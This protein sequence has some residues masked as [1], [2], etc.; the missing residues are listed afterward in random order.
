M[1]L[2]C[3][4]ARHSVCVCGP[5]GPRSCEAYMCVHCV[6][7]LYVYIVC[8]C[9]VCAC[10]QTDVTSQ[11]T[12]PLHLYPSSDSRALPC[13]VCVCQCGHV[14]N[15]R[16]AVLS[17]GAACPFPERP[18]AGQ[19]VCPKSGHGPPAPISGCLGDIRAGP[20]PQSPLPAAWTGPPFSPGVS[21]SPMALGPQ[22]KGCSVAGAP[23]PPPG[24]ALGPQLP[25]SGPQVDQ[26]ICKGL[27]CPFYASPASYDVPA[28]WLLSVCVLACCL[29]AGVFCMFSDKCVPPA[30]AP[31]TIEPTCAPRVPCGWSRAWPG[32]SAPLPPPPCSHPSRS[33]LRV[34]PMYPWVDTRSRHA[35]S[36]YT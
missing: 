6:C 13:P 33:T 11:N 28:C 20:S 4:Q 7:V 21:G 36:V 1:G 15:P 8:V 18:S 26:G 22:E 23:L 16:W 35:L 12:V 10:G 19:E 30:Q 5:Q 24:V 31:A 25:I 32:L 3:A 2:M 29:G 27:L 14:R 34:H 17:W 9:I